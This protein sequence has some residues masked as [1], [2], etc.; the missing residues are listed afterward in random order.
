[1]IGEPFIILPTIDS[2]NNY[3]KG[4]IREGL[5]KDGMVIFTE[6]QTQGR[7]QKNKKWEMCQLSPGK[8][9]AT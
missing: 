6:E 2:T 4:L 9:C 7:A 1:M 5:A 3:A 8:M